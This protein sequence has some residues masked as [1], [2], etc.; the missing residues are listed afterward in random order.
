MPTASE[1]ACT[2][3][4][5]KTA[6]LVA[7]NDA[8]CLASH[9]DEEISAVSV[10]QYSAAESIFISGTNLKVS[11]MSKELLVISHLTCMGRHDTESSF[12]YV[13][14]P[15]LQIIYFPLLQVSLMLALFCTFLSWCL[16]RPVA[17]CWLLSPTGRQSFISPS[18]LNLLEFYPQLRHLRTAC[19]E[20]SYRTFTHK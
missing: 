5:Q 4:S 1:W 11:F 18:L 6:V 2:N 19:S 12:Y 17:R 7:L 14:F 3:G 20:S 16:A 13:I 10:A 9:D 8:L 15:P